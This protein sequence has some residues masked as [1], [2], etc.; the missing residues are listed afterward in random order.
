MGLWMSRRHP[1]KPGWIYLVWMRGIRYTVWQD[2]V[3]GSF[4][5]R[6]SLKNSYIVTMLVC[7]KNTWSVDTRGGYGSGNMCF[8]DESLPQYVLYMGFTSPFSVTV[9][10]REMHSGVQADWRRSGYRH[11]LLLGDPLHHQPGFSVHKTTAY[12]HVEGV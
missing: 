4:S 1:T 7:M 6:V 8:D 5:R 12:F 10:K 2:T 9:Y 3:Q 11:A